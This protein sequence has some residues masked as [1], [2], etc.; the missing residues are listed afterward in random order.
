MMS[1]RHVLPKKF[2]V[3]FK[4]KNPIVSEVFELECQLSPPYFSSE[5]KEIIDY[6][7]LIGTPYFQI[8]GSGLE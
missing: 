7:F 2:Y 3:I 5:D 8:S 1:K 4:I 6:Y